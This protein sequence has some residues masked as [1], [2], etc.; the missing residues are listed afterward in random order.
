M[1]S[2]K[3][4]ALL[5]TAALLVPAAAVLAQGAPPAVLST[6]PAT[7]QAGAYTLDAGHGRIVWHVSHRGISIWYGDFAK[8]TGTAVLDPKNPAAD[9]VDIVIPTASVSTTNAKLDGELK[10][11][12]WFD[13]EKFPTIHFKSTKVVPTGPGAADVTGDLTFHG[14]TKSVKLEVKFRAAG[15][16]GMSTRYNVGF[17]A[18]TRIKRSDFGVL[19]DLPL[20]G[21]DVH[22][23]ISAPFYK[24]G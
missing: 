12:D 7:V 14:V 23:V 8:P 4:A 5:A 24:A 13:A 10:S 17:D 6:D 11:P 9:S 22:I 1:N 16:D 21:D 15:T 19:T 3:F 18:K 20:I 2:L